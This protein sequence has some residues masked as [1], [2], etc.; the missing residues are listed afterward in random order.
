MRRAPRV[1]ATS[2]RRRMAINAMRPSLLNEPLGFL[3]VAKAEGETGLC[4]GGNGE[5]GDVVS[6]AAG[7]GAEGG[8]GGENAMDA[9]WLST[10]LPSSPGVSG[11]GAGTAGPVLADSEDG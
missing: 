2:K 6:D 7:Q 1:V 8:F 3:S 4:G 9:A 5:A 10:G 11:G